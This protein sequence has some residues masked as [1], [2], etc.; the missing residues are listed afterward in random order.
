MQQ[1]GIQLVG[2]MT[3]ERLSAHEKEKSDLNQKINEKRKIIKEEETKYKVLLLHLLT[4]TA[5]IYVA[6]S[7]TWLPS[8]R[9]I[10]CDYKFFSPNLPHLKSPYKS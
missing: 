2:V 8:W 5:S 9:L 3:P 10:S 1:V 7:N 4:D 6:M